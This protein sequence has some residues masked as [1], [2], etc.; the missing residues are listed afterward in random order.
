M[1]EIE[2]SVSTPISNT[3]APSHTKPAWLQ[4]DW[5]Q[6]GTEVQRLQVR[7]AKATQERRWGKIKALQR[8]ADPIILRQEACGKTI[9][10]NRGKRTPGIDGKTWSTPA[11]K[12]N[13]VLALKPASRLSTATAKPYLH[14]QK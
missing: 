1:T 7:I 6:I 3:G 13:G 14:T 11:A 2:I 4:A 5:N 9:T 8:K 10:E 12:S